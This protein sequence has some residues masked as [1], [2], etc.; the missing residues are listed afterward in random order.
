M[1]PKP[2]TIPSGTTKIP[3]ELYSPSGTASTGLVVIAYGTD[4]FEDTA[5]GPWKTMI[6]GYAE[7]LAKRGFFALVPDYFRRTG[8]TPG[9]PAADVIRTKHG[10]WEQALVDSVT[11]ARTMARVDSARIGLL[12]FSLGGYLCLSIRA[13]A[14]PLALV[15]YFAPKFDG[16]GPAGRVPHA[17]IHHG[18]EDHGPA[19]DF[20]NAAAIEAI[21]TLEKT[22]VTLFP[23]KGA[24][25]GFAAKDKANMEASTLSRT[26][27]LAFFATH[28]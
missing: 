4:G 27:T 2:I 10:D 15:E 9:I 28:L 1:T 6:R 16:I 14:K 17:Q 23:Y 20:S 21:L 3:G 18:E 25:H 22:A 26:R 8:T 7:E 12:G 24:G 19:T 11:H 13:A 5:N